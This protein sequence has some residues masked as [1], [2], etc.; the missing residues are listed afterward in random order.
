MS[1]IKKNWK[2]VVRLFYQK[3]LVA[4]TQKEAKKRSLFLFFSFSFFLEHSTQTKKPPWTKKGGRKKKKV[5]DRKKKKASRKTKKKKLSTEALYKTG[6]AQQ[7]EALQNNDRKC[8][9]KRGKEVK[10]II[11]KK[12][13]KNWKSN[14]QQKT[15]H[16][17]DV[18]SH[19]PRAQSLHALRRDLPEVVL[20][21][22]QCGCAHKRHVRLSFAYFPYTVSVI[23]PVH[24][25]LRESPEKKKN[26]WT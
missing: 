11:K 25:N 3:R 15:A 2:H 26:T 6:K 22:A 23:N 19:L 12:K 20:L 14:C 21:S 8:K 4:G 5:Q 1:K 9:K 10:N 7:K 24:V 17:K 13:K 18:S 16:L